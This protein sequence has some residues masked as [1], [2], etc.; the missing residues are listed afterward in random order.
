MSQ[1]QPKKRGRPRKITFEDKYQHVLGKIEA[2]K[3]SWFLT[4]SAWIDWEDVKQIIS[5]HVYN[6][7][8]LWDQKR[9]L[10]PWLN[11]II[12]N[13]IKNWRR[14]QSTQMPAIGLL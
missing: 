4:S 13:Q 12:S 11:R 6:K 1:D 3:K 7:W 8:H 10:D 2:R 14:V 9:N 5:T